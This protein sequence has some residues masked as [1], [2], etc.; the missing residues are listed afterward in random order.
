MF[1]Y[2]QHLFDTGFAFEEGGSG[3]KFDQNTA[4]GPDINGGQ[5]TARA[6][7]K[8]RCFVDSWASFDRIVVESAVKGGR[9]KSRNNELMRAAV[10]KNVLGVDVAM[11]NILLLEIVHSR[12]DLVEVE[13]YILFFYFLVL[14]QLVQSGG[15]QGSDYV[16]VYDILATAV[17]VVDD[18][19]D[20]GV[21]QGF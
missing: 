9:R 10:D 21:G 17:V 11:H 8:F 20:I 16:Q 19:D 2:F 4:E 7:D 15:V 6:K 18:L 14:D 12:K 3:D 13:R 5:V 1:H